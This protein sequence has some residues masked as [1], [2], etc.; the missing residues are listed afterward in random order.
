MKFTAISTFLLV[1]LAFSDSA[2]G[3]ASP[4]VHRHVH[5]RA[6]EARASNIA[7]SP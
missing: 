5:R 2:L 3:Y 1:G 4:H 7:P 6:L